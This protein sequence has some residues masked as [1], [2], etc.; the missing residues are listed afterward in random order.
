MLWERKKGVRWRRLGAASSAGAFLPL[1]SPLLSSPLP[2]SPHL[3]CYMMTQS[4]FLSSGC[5]TVAKVSLLS[6]QCVPSSSQNN[7]SVLSPAF[8]SFRK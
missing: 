1:P 5:A 6:V 7:H 8:G 4:S 2:S 3:L